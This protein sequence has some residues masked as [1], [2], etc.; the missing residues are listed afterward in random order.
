VTETP[1]AT[2]GAPVFPPGRYGR[3]RSPRTR[4]RRL[5]V[6]TV[7]GALL[8]LVLTVLLY[9]RFGAATYQPSVLGFELADDHVTVRFEVHKPADRAAVCRVRARAL[10]GNEVGAADVAVPTGNP[11]VVTYTLPTTAKPVS[12]EVP[13]C[14]AAP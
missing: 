4:A 12:A 6:L 13:R 14:A 2:G 9:V 10:A 1:P 5:P 3:R 11:V 7:L 8:G